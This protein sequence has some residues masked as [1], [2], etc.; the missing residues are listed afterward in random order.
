LCVSA[1][2][3][4]PEA[5][6]AIPCGSLNTPT[7][8]NTDDTRLNCCCSSSVDASSRHEM[9]KP[10]IAE[11][12]SQ[13]KRGE[14][15]IIIDADRRTHPYVKIRTIFSVANVEFALVRNAIPCRVFQQSSKRFHHNEFNAG[16]QCVLPMSRHGIH[17]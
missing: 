17:H 3:T 1:T 13:V 9:K 7:G 5:S 14:N 6:T 10:T 8:M 4:L 16:N 2:Q 11:R 12:S 15:F